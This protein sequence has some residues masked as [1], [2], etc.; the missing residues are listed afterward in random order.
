MKKQLLITLTGLVCLLTSCTKEEYAPVQIGEYQL[1]LL[2]NKTEEVFIFPDNVT[3]D[4]EKVENSIGWLDVV[5]SGQAGRPQLSITKTEQAPESFVTGE[6]TVRFSLGRFAT[7]TVTTEKECMPGGNNSTDY[8]AFNNEWWT[9]NEIL[10]TTT[11]SVNGELIETSEHIPLPWAIAATSNIP[12]SIIRET[13]TGEVSLTKDNGWLMAYNLFDSSIDGHT[14][15]KPY[16]SLY[17]KF[18]GILRV[19][20]YQREN[21]GTGGEV[22]FLVTP[23]VT[24]EMYNFYNTL[25]YGIPTFE[26]GVKNRQ[27]PQGMSSMFQQYVTPYLVGDPV[28]KKGWYCFDL[29]FSAYNSDSPAFSAGDRITIECKTTANENITL[30]G[31]LTGKADGSFESTTNTSISTSNGMNSLDQ[32]NGGINKTLEC[33]KLFAA[34]DY[35]KAI[36]YGGLSLWNFRNFAGFDITDDYTSVSETTGSINLDLGADLSLN[37]Y[38]VSNSSNSSESVDFSPMAFN[39][40]PAIC[41]GVWSLENHPYLY[42]DTYNFFGEDE[43]FVA[44]I[45]ENGYFVPGEDLESKN[46]RLFAY[47]EPFYIKL[48]TEAFGEI[49]NVDVAWTWGVYPNRETGFTQKYRQDVLGVWPDWNYQPVFCKNR[50]DYLGKFLVSENIASNMSN[51]YDP[52]QSTNYDFKYRGWMM[53]DYKAYPLKKDAQP[54]FYKQAGQDSRYYG[55]AINTDTGNPG[56]LYVHAPL[57]LLPTFQDEKGNWYL[58]DLPMIDFVVG[59]SVTVTHK[60]ESGKTAVTVLSKKFLPMIGKERFGDFDPVFVFKDDYLE[61]HINGVTIHNA[62]LNESVYEVLENAEHLLNME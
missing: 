18:T 20:Y 44:Q 11:T 36:A 53:D 59:V 60:L 24:G 3:Y 8:S 46:I 62:C 39:S 19:F 23:S 7:V 48:N 9:Q 56:N 17:N 47:L 37:G 33:F 57:L 51:V 15:S 4:I 50:N 43:Y 61:Y 35:L 14:I 10:Y 38:S 26:K 58:G 25:E 13:S 45:K 30:L 41:K 5:S 12:P 2:Q 49:L 40:D 42:I 32:F 29:D 52:N 1:L 55:Y 31:S 22:S 28:L 21:P 6:I 16:F 34:G 27:N 54:G